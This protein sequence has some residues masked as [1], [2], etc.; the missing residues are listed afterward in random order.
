[1]DIPESSPVSARIIAAFVAEAAAP[2]ILLYEFDLVEEVTRKLGTQ[3]EWNIP[4]TTD[5]IQER[6][7]ANTYQMEVD[8]IK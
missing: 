4:S 2:E 8:R 1:M 7:I 3:K 6:A 5:D